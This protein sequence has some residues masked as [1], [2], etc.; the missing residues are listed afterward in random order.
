M[1]QDMDII[2]MIIFSFQTAQWQHYLKVD[3]LY[4]LVYINVC[5][6]IG[7]YVLNY[8]EWVTYI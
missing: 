7:L 5:E 6:S 2:D 1:F 8:V 3:V 4:I